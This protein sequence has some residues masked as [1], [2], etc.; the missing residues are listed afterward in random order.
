MA[1][2]IGLSFVFVAFSGDTW[3]AYCQDNNIKR[4]LLPFYLIIDDN[5]FND[6]YKSSLTSAYMGFV[7]GIAFLMGS[8]V[9][10]GMLISM[11]SNWFER[12]VEGYRDGL[13]HYLRSDHYVIM[14][15]DD[16]VPSVI[17]DIFSKESKANILVMT[18]DEVEDIKEKLQKSVTKAQF[19]R[20]VV[21]YGQRTSQDDYKDIHLESAKEI[22]IVG[23]RSFPAHDA[24]NVECVDNICAYLRKTN[25]SRRPRRIT[26]VFED[27]DTYA[28]FKT[29]NIF[30]GVSDLGIEFIPYNFYSGWANQVF[31]TRSYKEK[32]SPDTP[33]DYPSV[34][35]DG[36]GVETHKR[37]HLVFVGTSNLSVSFAM[38]AAHLFHFPNFNRDHSLRTRITFIEI[39]ADKEM[40]LFITRNRHFFDIQSYIYRDLSVQ[41]EP[42]PIQGKKSDFLDVE[43]E[44]IK[45][46]V[47]S[48]AVQNEIRHWATDQG[49][50]LSIFLSMA[51]QRKNFMMG[52]NMPDEVYSHEVPVFIRQDRADSFVTSLREAQF[53]PDR[54]GNRYYSVVRDGKLIQR[55]RKGRYTNLYPFGMNDMTQGISERIMQQAKLINFLY[56]NIDEQGVFPKLEEIK[57]RSVEEIWS[58]AESIWWKLSVAEQWSNLYGAYNIPCK[59]AS[60]RAMRN[61]S[62][63]DCSRDLDPLTEEEIHELGMTEHN[64][65]NVEK[66]LMGFRKAGEE[67]DMY[68]HPEYAASLQ[69]NKKQFVHHDIRPFDELPQAIKDIDYG[70]VEFIPWILEMTSVF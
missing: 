12:R 51:D 69:N 50:I 64:R 2:A 66:L 45:G 53:K 40:P 20:I 41:P 47:F 3:D 13:I 59:L 18:S 23:A 43:F 22:Y 15:Y 5:A 29:S 17:A 49:Q 28:A 16:M 68:A 48:D 9:F 31:V 70:I 26:C 39:N 56:S 62:P 7:G 44:F 21:N 52:V 19:K 67:E 61:L 65:W 27:I 58:D 4:W 33:I 35:G 1:I 63:S 46:D 24:I 55:E 34:Y 54:E 30:G 36:V 32:S 14:G 42:L 38:E 57:A 37:V 60:L 10:A 25:S 11:I 6:L 8:I